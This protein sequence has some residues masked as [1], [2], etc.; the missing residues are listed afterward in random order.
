MK[1]SGHCALL[2]KGTQKGIGLSEVQVMSVTVELS[3]VFVLAGVL[4]VISNQRKG[5]NKYAHLP[6]P[7]GP[8]PLPF[9]GNALDLPRSREYATYHEWSKLYGDVVHTHAFGHHIIVLNSVKAAREMLDQRSSIFS[10]RP[11]IPMVH[12]PSL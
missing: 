5:K 1:E 8:K 2:Y 9:I 6:F 10:D 4:F 11:H 3:L 12:E 7:P